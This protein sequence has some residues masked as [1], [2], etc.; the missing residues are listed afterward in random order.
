MASAG[1]C[2]RMD[3]PDFRIPYHY[4]FPSG[5]FGFY[6][7]FGGIVTYIYFFTVRIETVYDIERLPGEFLL[8]VILLGNIDVFKEIRQS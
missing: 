4:G 3:I 5:F 2:L 8:I 6:E 1:N 7:V